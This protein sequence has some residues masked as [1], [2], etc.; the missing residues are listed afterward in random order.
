MKIENH[1]DF[2]GPELMSTSPMGC[3]G[4]AVHIMRFPTI[5]PMAITY[6]GHEVSPRV[7]EGDIGL[8]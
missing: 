3:S 1:S 5:S 2:I 7:G 8:R 4:H 6:A